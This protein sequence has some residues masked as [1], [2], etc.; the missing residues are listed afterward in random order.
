[1]YNKNDTDKFRRYLVIAKRRKFYGFVFKIKA[2]VV[3]DFLEVRHNFPCGR[4]N[5]LNKQM[6]QLKKVKFL[7]F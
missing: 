3:R 7:K 2:K 5:V 1:M 4:A 6:E